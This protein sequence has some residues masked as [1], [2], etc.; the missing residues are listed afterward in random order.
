MFNYIFLSKK[1][2]KTEAEISCDP[3]QQI[4]TPLQFT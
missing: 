3:L 4:P 1:T 2:E